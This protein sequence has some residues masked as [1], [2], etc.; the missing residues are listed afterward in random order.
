MSEQANLID[1]IEE[2][3]RHLGEMLITLN[4]EKKAL[5]D[6][7]TALKNKIIDLESGIEV[8]QGM[9][10]VKPAVNP[11]YKEISAQLKL[12]IE[13]VDDCIQLIENL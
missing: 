7:V 3:V 10:T 1:G 9:R 13:E 6:E 4:K 12:Q 2:K 11:K 5:I 8:E